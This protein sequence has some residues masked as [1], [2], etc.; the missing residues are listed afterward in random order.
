LTD[1]RKKLDKVTFFEVSV[2]VSKLQFSELQPGLGLRMTV[3]TTSLVINITA[4]ELHVP[5]RI[6]KLICW[7]NDSAV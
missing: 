2:S 1:F 7:N 3:S 6:G 5:M 4:S